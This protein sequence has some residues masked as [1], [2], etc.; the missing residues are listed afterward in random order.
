MRT[1]AVAALHVANVFHSSSG[2]LGGIGSRVIGCLAALSR[3]RGISRPA[4]TTG[5]FFAPDAVELTTSVAVHLLVGSPGHGRRNYYALTEPY[6]LHA[7]HPRVSPNVMV[8][9][10]R[11]SW[12][13]QAIK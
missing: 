5:D 12:P 8:W 10:P 13:P 3:S 11:A 9:C 4:A 1:T 2:M 7:L 6:A